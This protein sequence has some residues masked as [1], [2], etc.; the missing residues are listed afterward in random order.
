MGAH[1]HDPPLRGTLLLGLYV[2][3]LVEVFGIINLHPPKGLWPYDTQPVSPAVQC[4]MFLSCQFFCV[5]GGIRIAKTADGF[6]S[7][8]VKALT[9]GMDAAAMPMGFAPMLAPLLIGARMRALNLDPVNGGPPA[10]GTE[11]F[12]LAPTPW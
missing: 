7:F 3:A 10:V 1:E 4:V 9:D 5:F 11:L 12:L 6:L 8:E 2:G